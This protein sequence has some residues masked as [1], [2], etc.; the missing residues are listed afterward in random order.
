MAYPGI[1]RNINILKEINSSNGTDL[2]ELYRPGLLNSL[3]VVSNLKYSGFLTSLRLTIDIT[4]ISELLTI[5]SDIL[6]SD[7]RIAMNSRATFEGNQK[8]CLTFYMA[9]SD[10][11]LIKIVDVYLFNQ[12]PY[13]YVDVLKYFTSA[14]TFDIAPDAQLCAKITEAGN[15]ILQNEDR[16]LL[17]GTGIEE[18]PVYDQSFLVAE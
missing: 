10:T 11:P 5:P 14:T 9:T 2:I 16:I 15:G 17:L 12:R 4:S 7:E 18:S 1:F 13:Y 6:A 8:K 3:D